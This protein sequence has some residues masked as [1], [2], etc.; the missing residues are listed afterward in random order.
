MRKNKTL[1]MALVLCAGLM[2]SSCIG[3]FG[4]FNRTVKWNQNIGN[5]FANEL[6]F[7]ALNI[8]PVYEV[9]YLADVLVI[10]SIEFWSGNN[11]M[12]DVGR[13]QKVKGENGNFYV[14]TLANGYNITK[15]DSEESMDLLFDEGKQTWNIV[16]EGVDQPLLRMNENGTATLFMPDGSTL[17]VTLDAQGKLQAASVLKV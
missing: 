3:S 12:A 14:K 1:A 11:P 2:A 9:C 4:L 10:N 15:E 17:D 6:V 7:L 5:K 13:I 16:A 8:V